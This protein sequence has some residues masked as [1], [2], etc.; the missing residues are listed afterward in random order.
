MINDVWHIWMEVIAPGDPQTVFYTVQFPPVFGFPQPN[1]T[2]TAAISAFSQGFDLDA[3]EAGA[4]GANVTHYQ[5]VNAQ[6]NIEDV[7]LPHDWIYN[8]IDVDQAY[9]VTFALS[10]KRAWAYAMITIDFR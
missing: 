1:I 5:H 9:S 4:V 7:D 6:G 3:G 10:A 2:A 8:A